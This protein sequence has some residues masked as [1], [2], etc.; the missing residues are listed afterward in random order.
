MGLYKKTKI[1]NSKLHQKKNIDSIKPDDDF[2]E[3]MI[4]NNF[5]GLNEYT[6]SKSIAGVISTT[7]NVLRDS[8]RFIGSK[9]LMYA[10]LSIA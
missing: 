1:Q 4:N 6:N 7:P 2:F 10:K 3:A 8:T 9:V 5:N